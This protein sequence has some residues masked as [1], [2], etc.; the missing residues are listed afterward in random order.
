MNNS[1]HISDIEDAEFT[2]VSTSLGEPITDDSKRKLYDAIVSMSEKVF[3]GRRGQV[4]TLALTA[5]NLAH[6]PIDL[7]RYY[8]QNSTVIDGYFNR[9]DMNA[10]GDAI[11]EPIDQSIRDQVPALVVGATMGVGISLLLRVL[12][13]V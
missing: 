1:N 3:P 7:N 6:N 4:F 11:G 2:E 5:G 10:L 12:K 13:I 9:I 8:L